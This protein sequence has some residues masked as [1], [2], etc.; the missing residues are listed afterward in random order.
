MINEI[1]KISGN[2]IN[3]QNSVEFPYS[4]NEL[5][6]KEIKKRIPHTIAS[7]RINQLGINLTKVFKDVYT[8]NYKMLMK[9]ATEYLN[10]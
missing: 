8:E 4:N 5:P 3:M 10:K 1:S 6:E 7:K 9:E 2:K